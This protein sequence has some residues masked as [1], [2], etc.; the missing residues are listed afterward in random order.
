VSARGGFAS[1][2]KIEWLQAGGSQN[3]QFLN[4]GIEAVA[5]KTVLKVQFFTRA[6]VARLMDD[7]PPLRLIAS[8]SR[9]V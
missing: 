3:S 6:G 1:R 9:Y 8:K 4:G 7:R 5:S 2:Q